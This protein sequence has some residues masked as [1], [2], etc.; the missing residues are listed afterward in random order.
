MND[1]ELIYKAHEAIGFPTIEKHKQA[2]ILLSNDVSILNELTPG[3]EATYIP[4]SLFEKYIT[5]TDEE[6]REYFSVDAYLEKL[7]KIHKESPRLDSEWY[8]ENGSGGYTFYVQ[9]RGG[10][11]HLEI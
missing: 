9:E 6:F 1:S 8:E 5:L 2:A 3:F 11:V 4:Y 10:L 7:S